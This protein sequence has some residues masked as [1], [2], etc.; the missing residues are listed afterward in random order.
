MYC[1]SKYS[2][3]LNELTIY[4]TQT[5]KAQRYEINLIYVDRLYNTV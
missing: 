3:S 4:L 2:K 5:K 1:I